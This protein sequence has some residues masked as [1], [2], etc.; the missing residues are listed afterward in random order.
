MP[1]AKE[2]WNTTHATATESVQVAQGTCYALFAY[3]IAFA[4]NLD[5]VERSISSATQRGS[6]KR[7]H[8]APAYFEYHPVNFLMPRRVT[9]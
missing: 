9:F 7:Q 4:L 1:D 2:P 8:P 6:I 5:E 3:D